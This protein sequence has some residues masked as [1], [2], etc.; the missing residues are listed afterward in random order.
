MKKNLTIIIAVFAF[1][2]LVMAVN[3]LSVRYFEYNGKKYKAGETFLDVEGCNTCSFDG[4]GQMACTLKACLTD[5]TDDS[6]VDISYEYIDGRY[7]YNAIVKKPTPC[8]KL[9]VE[10]VVR[11]SYPEQVDLNFTTKDSGEV[12]IQVID[13]EEVSGS[14]EVSKDATINVYLNGNLLD[15]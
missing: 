6:P 9:E 12:C 13:E 8:H 2:C 15:L 1:I 10:T 7:I 14:I 4:N 3:F 11:E 5:K